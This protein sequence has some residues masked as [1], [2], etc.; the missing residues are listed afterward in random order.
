MYPA[1]ETSSSFQSSL[2]QNVSKSVSFACKLKLEPVLVL[3]M[4]FISIAI[5]N[6]GGGL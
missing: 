3:S 6:I 1:T 4:T 5:K 2:L